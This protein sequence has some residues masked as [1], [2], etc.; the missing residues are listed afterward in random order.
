M[1]ANSVLQNLHG[2]LK[3]LLEKRQ[4]LPDEEQNLSDDEIRLIFVQILLGVKNYHDMGIL[5]EELL[6]RKIL[7]FRENGGD[8]RVKVADLLSFLMG[9]EKYKHAFHVNRD[10]MASTAPEV[11]DFGVFTK[12]AEVWPL[13]ILLY[14]LCENGEPLLFGRPN[15]IK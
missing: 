3:E 15:Q 5:H 12:K 6:L 1:L 13:G 14:S 2:T 11:Y 4:D 10:Y 8:I 7:V 9:A